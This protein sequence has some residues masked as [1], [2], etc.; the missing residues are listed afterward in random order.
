M[1]IVYE[2][3]ARKMLE[4]MPTKLAAAFREKI[5]AFAHD[6][7]HAHVD[8]KPLMGTEN[9]W[10]LRQGGWRAI[11]VVTDDVV[12]VETIGARGDVYK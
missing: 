9:S 2:K 3:S 5:K 11:L 10:R 6:P 1:K 7:R 8:V 12:F 4:K